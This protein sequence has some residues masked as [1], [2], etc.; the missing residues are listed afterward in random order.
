L[1]TASSLRALRASWDAG[2]KCAGVV[3]DESS[4]P[5]WRPFQ[6]AIW[7]RVYDAAC[8]AASGRWTVLR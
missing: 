1:A 4:D 3:T 6:W 8:A 2:T 7:L 5:V